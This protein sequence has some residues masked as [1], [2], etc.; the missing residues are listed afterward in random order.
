[1]LTG[2]LIVAAVALGLLS[3]GM[4]DAA[5]DSGASAGYKGVKLDVTAP[6]FELTDQ[7]GSA[8]SLADYRGKVVVLTL[9][10]PVCTD[11]CPVYANHYRLAYNALDEEEREEIVFLAFNANDRK[12][13]VE[14]VMSATEKWGLDRI[15]T[16]H[17]LTG[18]PEELADVWGAYNVEA[19]GDPKP[20]K[21]DELQHS[22][23]VFL[24]DQSGQLRRFLSTN[25]EGAPP[26]SAL[27]VERARA[28]LNEGWW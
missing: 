9:L 20:G 28:L 14:D 4:R 10:D 15:S 16:F 22:P 26:L 11:I 5:D 12:T 23:A 7:N 2:L 27:I 17:F 19:S 1:V 24:I 3:Y 18:S 8:V 6:A 21:P 13:S 25:F